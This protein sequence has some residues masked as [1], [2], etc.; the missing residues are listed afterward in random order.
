[1]SLDL[2]QNNDR[3]FRDMI[4]RGTFEDAQILDFFTGIW[5]LLKNPN[6]FDNLS[7]DKKFLFLLGFA[8]NVHADQR[9]DWLKNMFSTYK[10]ITNIP[11]NDPTWLLLQSSLVYYALS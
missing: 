8:R 10:T 1:M 9:L 2:I 3:P 11:D 4:N 6:V 7:D 5:S